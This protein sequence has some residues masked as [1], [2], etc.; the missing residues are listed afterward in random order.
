[1][2]LTLTG[3]NDPQLHRLTESM[4]EETEGPTGWFRLGQLMIKVAQFDKAEELYE[5]LLK[6]T[7]NEDEKGHLFHM[8]GLIKN[9]QGKYAEALNFMKNQLKSIKKLFLQI[10]LI[11]LLLTTTSVVVYYN[12]G[13][14][15]KALSYYEKA[16]EI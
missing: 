8:L 6:Q 12:M 1:M 5:I 13:E 2:E 3:D 9:D 15:S 4:R 7:T 16:L 11:W 14:Y 10:I